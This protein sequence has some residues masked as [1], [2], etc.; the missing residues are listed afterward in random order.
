MILDR[1]LQIPKHLYTADDAIEHGFTDEEIA[2]IWGAEDV[3]ADQLIIIDD[4][5]VFTGGPEQNTGQTNQ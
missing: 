1:D 5:V 3:K 4:H 2:S